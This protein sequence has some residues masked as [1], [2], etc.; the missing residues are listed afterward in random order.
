MID[1]VYPA[2]VMNPAIIASCTKHQGVGMYSFL[3]R[4]ETLGTTAAI[5]AMVTCASCTGDGASDQSSIHPLGVEVQGL[6]VNPWRLVGGGDFNF[7]FISDIVWHNTVDNRISVWLMNGSQPLVQGPDIAG[8]TGDGWAVITALDMNFDGMAD[9]LWYN[10]DKDL[11]AVWLMNGTRLLAAGPPIAGP[12]GVGWKVSGL[13]DFNHDGRRDV[14][15]YNAEKNLLAI[16]FM[17]G[18]VLLSR[19]QPIPGRAAAAESPHR[20]QAWA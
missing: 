7:D 4:A 13:G 8:P 10:S 9:V 15:W 2:C 1:D 17:N 14:L 3:K 11:I 12:I 6:N 18:S 5:S 16:W 20:G 19:G